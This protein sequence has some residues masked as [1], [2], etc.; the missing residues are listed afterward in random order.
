M[1]RRTLISS[2]LAALA[3]A[4]FGGADAAV[5]TVPGTPLP[6][7]G[8]SHMVVDGAYHHVFI[9]GASSDSVIVVRNEDGTS[10]GTITGESGAGGM[11]LDGSTLYVARCGWGTIDIINTATLTKI[12]SFSAAVGGTCDLAEA[13][14]RL[15]Y[16]DSTDNQFGH[17]VSVSLD[18]SH[19]V[20]DTGLSLY[21]MVFASSP[22][23]PNWLVIG[24]A[25]QS[26]TVGYVEDVTDP[27]HPV[28]LAYKFDLGGGGNLQDLAIS[29]DGEQLLT[30]SG[31][32]YQINAFSLPTLG[33]A[34]VYPT[35]NY[36]NAAAFSPDGLEIAGGSDAVYGKD[37]WLFD[38]GNS[39]PTAT[40]DF[41]GTNDELYPRGLAFSSDSK[42][43]FAVSRGQNGTSVVLHV[44]STSQ[45][46]T[47]SVSIHA[48]AAT[49]TYG[50]AVTVTAHLG[51][52]GPNRTLSIYRRPAAGGT[53]TLVKTGAVN[54]SGNLAVS[55][56]PTADTVYHAVWAGNVSHAE[57]TSGTSRVNVRVVMHA[58]AQGGYATSGGYRLYHY[59]SSC[60][61][62][63]HTGCPTFLT[64]AA[65]L[66]AN[67][68][69]TIVVQVHTS[70]GWTTAVRGS[71]TSGSSG[72]LIVHITYANRGVIGHQQRFN[73]SMG[74]D[75]DHLG[76]TSAWSYFRVT[77]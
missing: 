26:P 7:T 23:N 61:G 16:S 50:H 77:S 8:F 44:L 30:A 39:T 60:A 72:K 42:H 52:A 74:G 33:S 68:T 10:A 38:S 11:V 17:L 14:G 6:L 34:G 70:S 40:W 45:L 9:T 29:P 36:P 54:A 66:H 5:A 56:K 46:P 31:A 24:E 53:W 76:N 58:P 67:R 20:V 49:A 69:F 22:A 47:G 59:A 13:G 4:V 12:G 3:L 64:Y 37:V 48:S 21:E 18:S 25:H 63:A 35:T 65:P 51:T 27:A 75:A 1:R 43:L 55:V 41:G 73:V 19:T 32:P 2:T 15:W 28:Q 71:H 57:T 62:A